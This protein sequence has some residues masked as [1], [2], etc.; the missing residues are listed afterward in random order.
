MA[1]ERT[2]QALQKQVETAE[3]I[4][5]LREQMGMTQE[6]MAE[7]AGLKLDNYKKIESGE[8]AMSMDSL[9]GVQSAFDVSFDY[10]LDGKQDDI[11]ELWQKVN[12]YSKEECIE[13]MVKMIRKLSGVNYNEEKLKKSLVA[14]IHSESEVW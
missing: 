10:L 4:R 5:H 3:R 13:F 7:R 14:D 1:A 6:E 9:R 11:E 2:A 8:N 12:T